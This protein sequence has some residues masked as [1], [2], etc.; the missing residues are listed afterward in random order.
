M[1]TYKIL[2]TAF[3]LLL[4][5]RAHSLCEDVSASSNK[6][7]KDHVIFISGLNNPSDMLYEHQ[8]KN[9][10]N[11]SKSFVKLQGHFEENSS[12]QIKTVTDKIWLNQTR[13]HFCQVQKNKNVENITI[14]AFSLGGLL[15][16]HMLQEYHYNKISKV[17]LLA[18]AVK[19]KLP[20][21]VRTISKILPSFIPIPSLNESQYKKNSSI[22]SSTNLALFTLMDH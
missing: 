21:V 14:V 6:L 8:K 1:H 18:P 15:T 12:E 16:L 19:Q 22:Y 10:P 13:Q 3:I 9:Y 11:D 2:L 5:P 17:I 7:S 20:N 4:T